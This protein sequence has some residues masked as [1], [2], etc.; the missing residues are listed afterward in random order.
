MKHWDRE[1]PPK[2]IL[3][4]A[5][6]LRRTGL[7]R[8]TLYL[9]ISRGEFPRQVSLGARAGGWVEEEVDAWIKK[10]I[11]DRPESEREN[12]TWE[13]EAVTSTQESGSPRE[14]VLP[15]KKT[16]GCSSQSETSR[17]SRQ[18]SVPDMTQLELIGTNVYV[19]RKTG[20][21]WFQVLR[22]NSSGD[23]ST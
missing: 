19:E 11:R 21:L 17:A 3:R 10:R 6:V 12:W 2:T 18:R 22:P 16:A 9:R 14:A 23:S 7:S 13:G 5:E 20:A 4:Q 8:S 1:H 15:Q